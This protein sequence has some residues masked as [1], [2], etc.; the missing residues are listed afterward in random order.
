MHPVLDVLLECPVPLVVAAEPPSTEAR[1]AKQTKCIIRMTA[2]RHD[3]EE[4]ERK[5]DAR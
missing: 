3:K 5:R 2:R 1:Q 4:K